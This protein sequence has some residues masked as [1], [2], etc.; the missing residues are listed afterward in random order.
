MDAPNC[1]WQW[2]NEC[3]FS[4][5]WWLWLW[6]PENYPFAKCD[7]CL[8][9]GECSKRRRKTEI[10]AQNWQTETETELADRQTELWRTLSRASGETNGLHYVFTAA[11]A[12][13]RTATLCKFSTQFNAQY[14]RRQLIDP[15]E[16]KKVRSRKR[17]N[18]II[19][20]WKWKK[21]ESPSTENTGKKKKK[22]ISWTYLAL[23]GPTDCSL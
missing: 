21:G 9:S 6:L 22:K 15:R 19:K 20:S 7:K 10:A 5:W 1:K 12:A 8:C 17:E 23:C 18:K 4:H 2:M 11:T 16:R 13:T 14:P 3:E